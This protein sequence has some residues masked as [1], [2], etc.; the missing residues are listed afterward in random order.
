MK[1]KICG[2]TSA[3]DAM[4]ANMAAPDMAGMVFHPGSRRC[5]SYERAASIRGMLGRAVETV[6]VFVEG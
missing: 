3:V 6:G 1:V 5:V 2:L 4:Y